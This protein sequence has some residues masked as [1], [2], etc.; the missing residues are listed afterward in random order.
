ML[1]LRLA[2]EYIG[3]RRNGIIQYR[4]VKLSVQDKQLSRGRRR[5]KEGVF[6]WVAQALNLNRRYGNN[7]KDE[8][9]KA[10]NSQNKIF[11]SIL[12]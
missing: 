12:L 9:A 10:E 11:I 7:N 3:K 6:V 8:L 1:K 2:N 5:R 4:H